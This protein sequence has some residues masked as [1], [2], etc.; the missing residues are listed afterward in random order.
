MCK[1]EGCGKEVHRRELCS[2]HYQKFLK[3]GI[4]PRILKK[5]PLSFLRPDEI[6]HFLLSHRKIIQRHYK[7]PC[8]EWTLG[9]SSG[10]GI[11][12]IEGKTWKIPKL[13]LI[14][15][16]GI[17]RTEIQW[18]LH[19]CDNPSCFRPDHLFL[20]TLG[21]NVRDMTRKGRLKG[22]PITNKKLTEQQAKDILSVYGIQKP[23]SYAQ[24]SRLFGVSPATIWMLL[25]RK[26][27]KHVKVVLE[28]R[29]IPI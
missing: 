2:T 13:S 16:S 1:V 24:V 21:D 22:A 26:S 10:Y 5:Y 8:W 28:P 18:A 25:H 9:K 4:I 3:L 19:H 27:W 12:R 20:G 29:S 23:D 17:S 11:K 6:R 14:I 15:F 7:T